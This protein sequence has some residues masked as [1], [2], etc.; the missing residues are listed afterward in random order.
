MVLCGYADD[1]ADDKSAYVVAGWVST[2]EKWGEFTEDFEKAGL[3]R[4]LHMKTE[5]R[6]RGKRVQTLAALATV[7]GLYRAD[8]VLHRGN[9]QNIVK[10]RIA[11]ELDSPYF[12]LFYQLILSVARLMDKT[13][14]DGTV[15]WVFDDQGKIGIHAVR[16]Y[17]FIKKHASPNLKKRLGNTPVFRDDTKELPL[18]AADLFAWQIR[19]YIALEQ[20][21]GIQPNDILLRLAKYRDILVR[22]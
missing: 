18:K 16:W 22:L 12:V 11:P 8:C 9:Y 7:H 10:G 1:S 13:E 20:P 15:D 17:D 19:R 6:R 21:N 5:R 3:P 2:A 4:S 14:W